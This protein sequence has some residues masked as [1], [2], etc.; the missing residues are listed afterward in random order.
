[1]ASLPN[2]RALKKAEKALSVPTLLI[3]GKHDGCINPK[4]TIKN[5]QK[6]TQGKEHLLKIYQFENAG[7]IPFLEQT[8]L[9][10]NT[11]MEFLHE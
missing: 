6:K 3:V 2:M 4:T 8:D 1:M 11:I 10:Y 9:Y 7:H 5:F